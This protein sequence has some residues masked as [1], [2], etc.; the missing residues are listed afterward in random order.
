MKNYNVQLDTSNPTPAWAVREL[1]TGHIVE[2]FYFE[3][4]AKGFRKSLN[5][6]RAFDGWTPLFFLNKS[7]LDILEKAAT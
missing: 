4:D 2:R 7:H 6:G 1:P 3:E 5:K